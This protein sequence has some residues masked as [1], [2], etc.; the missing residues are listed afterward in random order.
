MFS[1]SRR[2]TLRKLVGRVALVLVAPALVAACG[3]VLGFKELIQATPDAGPSPSAKILFVDARQGNPES[4]RD[5]D[6]KT[7]ETAFA[8]IK[9]AIGRLA[10]DPGLAEYEIHVC[11]GDYQESGLEITSD[12]VLRGG[13]DC[14]TWA[15]P[16]DFGY[17][18]FGL[19]SVTKLMAPAELRP[20]LTV[21]GTKVTAA[22]VI[23]GFTVLGASGLSSGTN[24]EETGVV[25]FAD[26]SAAKFAQSVVIGGTLLGT[27]MPRQVGPA[28]ILSYR[29]NPAL[30]KLRATGGTVGSKA[31][32]TLVG[33][34]GLVVEGDATAVNPLPLVVDTCILR[35]NPGGSQGTGGAALPE[36]GAAGILAD[37]S[38]TLHITNSTVNGGTANGKRFPTTGLFAS[39]QS[40]L[41]I[42]RS[43]ID[44][45]E[46]GLC[47]PTRSEADPCARSGISLL[48]SELL[49]RESVVH[50]GT[51]VPEGITFG[52]TAQQT[53]MF[54]VNNV[55][56]GGGRLGAAGEAGGASTA[57]AILGGARAFADSPTLESGLY[58]NTLILGLSR[59]AP[60]LSS[61]INYRPVLPTKPDSPETRG[62][63]FVGNLIVGNDYSGGS[64]L[65][66]HDA[67]RSY[68]IVT[69]DCPDP[70]L[71]VQYNV[72]L[73]VRKSWGNVRCGTSNIQNSSL[74]QLESSENI[75]GD[76]G[77]SRR[78]NNAQYAVQCDGGDMDATLCT[79]CTGTSCG[80]GLIEN[81]DEIRGIELAPGFFKANASTAFC[82]LYRAG[83]PLQIGADGGAVVYE[84]KE[85]KPRT[86]P[87]T[88]GA[89]E[90]DCP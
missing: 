48:T 82:S 66:L 65:S 78:S 76:A 85:G 4:D 45:G 32:L 87:L 35:G 52:L 19:N 17:P 5:R 41:R 58:A 9:N 26:G 30:Q 83:G 18:I 43:A 64:P 10:T 44:G 27:A 70:K 1:P 11:A 37:K 12:V 33:S 22:T 77:P 55:L 14:T 21:R 56:H 69:E 34:A 63:A 61:A 40:R 50:G 53:K 13:Y 88:P 90:V 29:A 25:L 71:R 24:Y 54:L 3:Q 23:E 75:T 72:L 51:V 6:G 79:P 15:R 62:W 86:A 31:V 39:D 20:T 16:V 28:A 73:D 84:D 74:T 38:A 68:G 67:A 46:G 80:A 89:F 7:P 81:F 59:A 47:I 57:V 36:V 49:L 8:S 42:D 2:V 60:Y